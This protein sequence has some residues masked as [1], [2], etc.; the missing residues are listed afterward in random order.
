MSVMQNPKHGSK[1][2]CGKCHTWCA[3]EAP[4]CSWCGAKKQAAKRV[5][6]PVPKKNEKK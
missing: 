3:P 6:S 5:P 1:W 2:L 4:K